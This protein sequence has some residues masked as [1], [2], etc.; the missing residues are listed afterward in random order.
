MFNYFTWGGYLLY[1][2]WPQDTVFI[3]GQTDFYG[4]SLTR[5]YE[6]VMYVNQGWETVLEK[7]NVDWVIVPSDT[8]LVNSLQDELDWIPIYHDDTA[9]ILRKP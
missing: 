9:S 5:E 6:Q 8:P 3:D 2:L 7:Y 1:R 4:E